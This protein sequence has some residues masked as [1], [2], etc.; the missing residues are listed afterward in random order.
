[1]RVSVRAATPETQNPELNVEGYDVDQLRT[2]ARA[3]GSATIPK[4]HA[5][6]MTM[7]Q[8]GLRRSLVTV[9]CDS[10]FA[11]GGACAIETETVGA[12]SGG[13]LSAG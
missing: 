4:N 13:S 8:M 10:S 7:I 3:T 6:P 11:A 1:L 2:C 9:G 5:M 12:A